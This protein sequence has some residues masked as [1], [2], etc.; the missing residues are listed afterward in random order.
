MSD[1]RGRALEI[2]PLVRLA[3]QRARLVHAAEALLVAL[4]GFLLTVAAGVASGAS[5]D[6]PHLW[7]LAILAA[8][9]AASLSVLEG[10]PDAEQLAR[11]LDQRLRLAGALTT[12]F[13]AETLGREN[14]LT[15][16]LS[17]RLRARVTVL[18]VRRV[19]RADPL[20]W[21]ALPLFAAALLTIALG[22]RPK[23]ELDSLWVD[24]HL[25]T[26]AHELHEVVAAGGA[27]VERDEIDPQDYDAMRELAQSASQ[28]SL[29]FKP[30]QGGAPGAQELSQELEQLRDRAQ[31]LVET[32]EHDSELRGALEKAV[33]K[34]DETLMGML[35]AS[36]ASGPEG[37]EAQLESEL[38]DR[39]AE[40]PGDPRPGSSE[41][42]DARELAAGDGSEPGLGTLPAGAGTAPG[43][44][45]PGAATGEER[46]APDPEG[47]HSAL[48]KGSEDGTMT[49][50]RQNAD[51]HAQP[52]SLA[53]TAFG[54]S[55]A[56]P[57]WSERNAKLAT[58]WAVHLRRLRLDADRSESKSPP[59]NQ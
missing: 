29:D 42:E 19:A 33:M 43:P 54:D 3:L 48:A 20:P 7:G 49:G 21:L 18:D 34:A 57:W 44:G 50:S 12:A 53:S 51:S 1:G 28:L 25:S 22:R 14:E 26:L 8:A 40:T 9:L 41:G 11:H 30:V 32:L 5:L 55:S 36:P 58:S 39:P 47:S 38:Q 13:R 56:A 59:R 46:P 23:A 17:T 27:C 16:L 24:E 4:G 35:G 52:G 15:R 37:L 31:E 10:R 2:A 45:S 6:A